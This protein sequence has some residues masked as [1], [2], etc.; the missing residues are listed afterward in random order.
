M[1]WYI[2][3]RQL[4]LKVS[5]VIIIFPLNRQRSNATW[6]LFP[7]GSF[8]HSESFPRG[9]VLGYQKNVMNIKTELDADRAEFKWK[10]KHRPAEQGAGICSLC[11]I[12]LQFWWS[13]KVLER[14]HFGLQE[15]TF[16]YGIFVI[17]SHVKSLLHAVKLG[18][19]GKCLIN[20]FSGILLYYFEED[21]SFFPPVEGQSNNATLLPTPAPQHLALMCFR[22][23]NIFMKF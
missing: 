14:Y 18:H 12:T 4:S 5:A 10:R 3:Y 11:I 8:G 19:R 17:F 21:I 20:L 13:T 16:M 6:V 9:N 23:D 7:W 22:S 1:R 2:L 15:C